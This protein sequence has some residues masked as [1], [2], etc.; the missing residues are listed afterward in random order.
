MLYPFADDAG[1]I[2][3]VNAAQNVPSAHTPW[4]FWIRADDRIE[5]RANFGAPAA[6]G[7]GD[8]VRR[9]DDVDPLCR[10]PIISAGMALFNLRLAIRVTGH[11]VAAWVLPDPDNDPS[12]LA[13][14]E[15]V[16]GRIRRP[17]VA[18]QELYDAISRRRMLPE[19]SDGPPVP[20]NIVAAMVIAS[21]EKQGWL[22]PL[23]PRQA[24]TWLAESARA[25]EEF[26]GDGPLSGELRRSTGQGTWEFAA[27]PPALRLQPDESGNGQARTGDGSPDNDGA[28]RSRDRLRSVRDAGKAVASWTFLRAR[29][30]RPGSASPQLLTLATRGDRPLDW[31]NA[32]QA[33]QRATLVGARFGVSVAF[34]AQPLQLADLRASRSGVPPGRQWPWGKWPFAE[35]PQLVLRVGHPGPAAAGMAGWRSGRYPEVLDLRGPQPRRVLPPGRPQPGMAA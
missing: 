2:R 27:A 30:G 26:A 15:V 19:G 13:S 18:I 32:G 16:T 3:V 20:E 4:A 8:Q 29:A 5:L 10:E 35:V 21:F 12:L 1:I 7:S 11:D 31:L 6:R 17:S 14:V 33:V 9:L 25:E 24:K 28:H 34:L 23:N 22:R